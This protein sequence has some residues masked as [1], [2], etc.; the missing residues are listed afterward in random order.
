[1]TT[2]ADPETSKNRDY[3]EPILF[4]LSS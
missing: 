3:S 1:M 4:P 2:S